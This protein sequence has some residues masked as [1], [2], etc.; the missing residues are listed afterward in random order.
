MDFLV[1]KND[2]IML[3]INIDHRE[4]IDI[5]ADSFEIMAS[6]L[7]ESSRDAECDDHSGN[8][9]MD[10]GIEHRIPEYKSYNYIESL[11]PALEDVACHHYSYTN[12]RK[13]EEHHIN[14][15]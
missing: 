8:G 13:D 10:A 14:M 9:S 6:T 5:L 12:S 4:L 1:G 15:G 2:G 11:R 3:V 7:L